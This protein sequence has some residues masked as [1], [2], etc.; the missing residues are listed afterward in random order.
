MIVTTNEEIAKYTVYTLIVLMDTM[1]F[2]IQNEGV[3]ILY[4]SVLRGLQENGD[5]LAVSA[6]IFDEQFSKYQKSKA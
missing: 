6:K 1:S 5:S 4:K 3:E 2:K